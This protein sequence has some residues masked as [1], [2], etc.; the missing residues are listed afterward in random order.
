MD[1]TRLSCSS[2]FNGSSIDCCI[3]FNY[4]AIN[5]SPSADSRSNFGI[6]V[7]MQVLAPVSTLHDK[8]GSNKSHCLFYGGRY[9]ARTCDPLNVV[10]VLYQLS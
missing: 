8:T 5:S 4:S 10:Q 1:D 7:G 2:A 3:I 6:P 9:K